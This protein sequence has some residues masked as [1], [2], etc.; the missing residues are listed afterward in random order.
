MDPRDLTWAEVNASRRS[1]TGYTGEVVSRDLVRDVVAEAHL[2]PSAFNS[3]PWRFV[4]AQGEDIARFEPALGGNA[5]KVRAAGTMVAVFAD[6]G[7]VERDERLAGFYDGSTGRTAVEYGARNG[8]LAAMA[9]MHAAWSHGIATRPMIGFDADALA[10]AA[11]V[12]DDW[13]PV[14]VVALGWPEDEDAA[15]RRRRPLDEV[16]RFAS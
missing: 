1:V 4:V 2:A 16:L 6:L 10:R 15:P 11:D 13:H 7:E 3:Q 8:G 12:P 9:L 14:M 5:G